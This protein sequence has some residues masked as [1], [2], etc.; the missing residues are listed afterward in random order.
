M[1]A[2]FWGPRMRVLI[3]A[4]GIQEYI[5]SINHQAAG[6]RLRGRS[7]QLGLVVDRCLELLREE[8][9]TQI[10]IKRNAGSCLDLKF[11]EIPDGFSHFV[12]KFQSQLDAYS[13]SELRG[14]VWFVVAY[15][16]SS[17]K[18]YQA[19]GKRK[20][21][22]GQAHLQAMQLNLDSLWQE[23]R[24]ILTA[25]PEREMTKEDA[26]KR[27][28]ARLGQKLARRENKYIWFTT[29]A[30]NEGE[31]K[32]LDRW[33]DAGER[34]PQEGPTFGLDDNAARSRHGLTRKYLARYAPLCENGQICDF[35]EIAER[36][37][38]AK[39]LGVLKADMDKL[40]ETFSSFPE[41]TEG[42]KRRKE[43]S[44]NLERLF[45]DELEG[46]LS[47]R[48]STFANCYVVYSGGDDLLMLGP[49]DQLIRFADRFH[50]LLDDS[51]KD[52]GYSSQLSLS[53]GFRLAHP[54]SPV[55]HLAD[56]VKKAL[57]QAKS[58]PDKNHICIF[59]RVLAWNELPA[60][61]AWADQF[62]R[63]IREQ[64]LSTGF[65]QRLQWY[66]DQ[67]RRYEQGKIEGLRMAALLQ[68]DWRRNKTRLDEKFQIEMESLIGLLLRP[69]AAEAPARWR[70]IDFAA[71]FALYAVR[72]K[73]GSQ[74]GQGEKF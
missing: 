66:A 35:D 6:K 61:L 55:R 26:E 30:S 18:A 21:R 68:N 27:P 50:S 32:A 2:S 28:E 47:S 41:S 58:H 57:E 67:F 36:S 4:S 63:G 17:A 43:L 15:G 13:L 49:W 24:F 16:E 5:F 40:G 8:Y 42:E 65:L 71:R 44:E 25:S 19:L 45:T 69:M 73:G 48:D 51:V 54:K 29:E 64:G 9:P 14:Q 74:N 52:W 10:K 60:G 37:T 3:T 31:I 53:A 12:E 11:T 20:L 34:P 62:I 59:Q 23:D 72:Q 39:F 46:L 56:D 1:D 38:G 70:E 22:I 7:A 33:V